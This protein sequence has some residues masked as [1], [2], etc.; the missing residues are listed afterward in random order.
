MTK[1]WAAVKYVK[2]RTHRAML[3]FARHGGFVV[4]F[5][6]SCVKNHKALRQMQTRLWLSN[7]LGCVRN[8]RKCVNY[9]SQRYGHSDMPRL[10]T[11]RCSR[12]TVKWKL[13]E[14]RNS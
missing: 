5:G 2:P 7:K 12:V 13:A 3:V 11:A 14:R 6:M 8:Y 1:H 4:C 10:E 9:I